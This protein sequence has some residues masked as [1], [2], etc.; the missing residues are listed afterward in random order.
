MCKSC[1]I[2]TEVR[3]C[4]CKKSLLLKQKEGGMLVVCRAVVLATR[5][6]AS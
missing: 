5:T 2:I 3:V 1:G 6:A 4:V